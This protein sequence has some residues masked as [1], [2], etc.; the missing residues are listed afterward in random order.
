MSLSFISNL[1]REFNAIDV[2]VLGFFGI[3]ILWILLQWAIPGARLYPDTPHWDWAKISRAALLGQVVAFALIYLALQRPAIRIQR[4]LSSASY[5]QKAWYLAYLMSPLAL[6]AMQFNLM[7]AFISVVS[8]AP[9]VVPESGIVYDRAATAIDTW[10]KQADIDAFGAYPAQW[11]QD[12]QTRFVTTWMVVCYVAYYLAPLVAT[13]P[14]LVKRN[15]PLARRITAV[16]AGGI[17][18]TYIGYVLFP[19]T[20]PRFEGTYEAW[21][22]VA[23]GY[24]GLTDV[25]RGLDAAE[26]I[27]WDAFPSGHVSMSLVG[28]VLAI[29][30]HRK[31]GL[32]YAPFALSL[33]FATVYL[34]YHFAWDVIAGIV[35]C[36][37]I[38]I[39]LEPLVKWWDSLSPED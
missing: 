27:R 1:R 37:L 31:I 5:R 29:K 4:K 12:R 25:Q 36:A 10:L 2:V 7:G 21:L 38:F 8:G 30:Y 11:L 33:V 13:I 26:V 39:G 28:M 16:Y 18:L 14:Q 17:L 15:W 35:L 19:S 6:I 24:F 22:P 20:G 32:A 3:E 9:P 23:E 34:G